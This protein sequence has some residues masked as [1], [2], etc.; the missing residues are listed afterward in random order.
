MNS[1]TRRTIEPVDTPTGWK[2][3]PKTSTVTPKEIEDIL[4]TAWK[5]KSYEDYINSVDMNF[6]PIGSSSETDKDIEP[7][8]KKEKK[9]GLVFDE[10]EKKNFSKLIKSK[11]SQIRKDYA[12][13][14]SESTPKE[15]STKE[16]STKE[17]STEFVP[18][19]PLKS[20]QK[21]AGYKC[22]SIDEEGHDRKNLESKFD[23]H[24][25]IYPSRNVFKS[26]YEMKNVEMGY[27]PNNPP[28]PVEKYNLHN[29]GPLRNDK[30]KK[31]IFIKPTK[32]RIRRLRNQRRPISK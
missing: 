15:S 26:A 7:L 22:A 19:E 24:N 16:S 6:T 13:E 28:K 25:R 10:I 1:Y 5:F 2:F 21:D 3:I 31:I 27:V 4:P 20:I 23:L 11:Q 17:S 32:P 30:D 14:V 29:S 8:Q 12:E 9:V 18:I